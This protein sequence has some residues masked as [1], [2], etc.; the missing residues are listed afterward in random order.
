M[1]IDMQPQWLPNAPAITKT[2]PEK[3]PWR[4]TPLIESVRLSKAAGW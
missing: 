1:A 3:K 4:K 2:K